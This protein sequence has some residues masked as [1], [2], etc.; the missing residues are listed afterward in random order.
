MRLT[1]TNPD[2]RL[3]RMSDTTKTRLSVTID[4]NALEEAMKVTGSRNKRETIARALEELVKVQ[5]RK[6]LADSIGT[7]IFGMT[8]KEL[9]RWRKR[10]HGRSR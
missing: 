1:G 8:G 9:L 3:V 2:A 5:R 7:G 10:S 4:T 6:A